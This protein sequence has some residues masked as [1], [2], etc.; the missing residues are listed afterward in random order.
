[1]FIM[2]T[3]T[4]LVFGK[5][6]R[7]MEK[8]YQKT[9]I[10]KFHFFRLSGKWINSSGVSS[11]KLACLWSSRRGFYFCQIN[12]PGNFR[13]AQFGKSVHFLIFGSY[14]VSIGPYLV[15]IEPYLVLI[16][17]YLIPIGPYLAL[18]GPI[19]PYWALFGPIGPYLALTVKQKR[20]TEG[21][22]RGHRN[23]ARYH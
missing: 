15:P 5:K 19:W 11:Q 12:I 14:L 10:V 8:R 7:D 21:P 6:G 18:L 1:M 17:P 13:H 9:K 3:R 4:T 22:H 2:T 16:G 23:S 20:N